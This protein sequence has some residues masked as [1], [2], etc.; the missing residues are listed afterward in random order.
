M[1]LF[2]S[3]ILTI[4]FI[5]L[6]PRFLWDAFQHGKYAAG[7]WERL[8]YLPE[9]EREGKKIIWLHCVSVGETNAAKPLAKAIL[10]N[11][12]NYKIV[13]STTTKTGNALAKNIFKSE[14]ALIFYFPF[15][16]A[17]I[18]RRALRR[19]KPDVVLIMETE[20][21][22]NF[23]RETKRQNIKIALVNGRLSEKSFQNYKI[24]RN[25]MRKVLANLDLAAMSGAADAQRI[26]DLGLDKE[27]AFVTGNIKFD[28]QIDESE[29]VLTKTFRERFGDN[30]IVCASTHEPEERLLLV[31]CQQLNS[32]RLIIVPRHPERFD[33][34]A[35]MLK[36]SGESFARRSAQSLET[37][38]TAKIVLLDSIGEL[39][40]IYP[41]A[42]IVFVGGSLIPHGGQNILEPAAAC[43]PVVTGFYT[44]N[45][46]SIVKTFV[47][48][49]AIIQLKEINIEKEIV[50]ALEKIFAEL[51]NDT[52][53]RR[54]MT[55][56]AFNV[57]RANSGATAQTIKKLRE[58][59]S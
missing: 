14:A 31:A 6:S 23:L 56:N 41:L 3:F 40:N 17:F 16:F 7:F 43:K 30:F 1:Y 19:I 52:E 35:E 38:K 2:Y 11:F 10:E 21:W 44:A 26:L 29:N 27:K 33:R 48:K 59:F 51:L 47:E 20:L 22:F 36:G 8:G 9:F 15:D 12:P 57:L 45:F 5:I 42:K 58:L 55:E 4:G 18:V 46:A 34:V 50:A 24:I 53:K 28:L 37:D 49:E 39:R 25:F 32:A 54:S 13:V